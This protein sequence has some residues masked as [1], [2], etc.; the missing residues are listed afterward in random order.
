MDKET[1]KQLSSNND[2]FDFINDNL[3]ADT[4][5]LRLKSFKDKSFDVNFAILQ[6]DCK[7]RIKKK[8][9]E[10][11]GNNKFLFPHILST[12]QC[13]AQEIAKF[14]ASLLDK[15]EIVLDMTAGLCIDTYYIS[16]TVKEVT[17]L[18]INPITASVSSFNMS[19]LTPNVNVINQDC[20]EFIKNTTNHY[21][22]IFIDPARRGEN[23]K[24]LFGLYDCTPNI[25]E[26]IPDLKKIS[27]TL[28][29]K[30]SPMLDITQSIRELSYNVTDIWILGINNEC[31][32][33][34]FKVDLKAT[35]SIVPNIHTINFENSNQ[36]TLSKQVNSESLTTA[37]LYINIE[38]G[39]YLYEPNSCIMKAQIFDSLVDKYEISAIS[40]NSHLFISNDYISDFPGRR[41]LITEVIPFKNTDIKN[42]KKIHPQINVSV[43]NFK[44]SADELK[45]KL[46]VKDGGDK[47]MFGTTDKA[48]N[49]L[50]LICNK[51]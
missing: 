44:L 51:A 33:I 41:F 8:L 16:K 15:N 48:N 22:S 45:K 32:E 3:S 14:H 27:N 23:N 34:L 20:I 4:N 9:P 31:K 46:K 1:L 30:A 26:L 47:Y 38:S 35:S 10:I 36:Q 37:P 50:L 42:I 6:I 43:R 13:T 40:P 28:Y 19:N 21:S 11:Y 12:E 5:K 17:A 18:E 29:I 25:L 49:A 24:R 7:N 2:F 39:A